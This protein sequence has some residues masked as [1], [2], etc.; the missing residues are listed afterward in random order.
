MTRDVDVAIV[1]GGPAGIAAAVAVAAQGRTPTLISDQHALGGQIWR[2]DVANPRAG[3]AKAWL[4]RLDASKC[5]TIL[6]ATAIDASSEQGARKIVLEITP[7]GVPDGVPRR[8]ELSAEAVILATG[9]RELF[10]PFPGWTLPGV[11][12][13]GG[14]QA[15]AK[16]GLDLDAKRVI[17]AGTGPL[18]IAVAAS[19]IHRGA[20]VVAIVEQAPTTR[21]LGFMA[22]LATAPRVARDALSY[23]LSL[24][25]GQVRFGSWIE[26]A[27][28]DDRI[29]RAVISNGRKKETLDCDYLAVGYGL[30]PN[31][32]IAQLMGCTISPSGIVVDERQETTVKGIFAAGE[33]VG[34]AG[35]D[36]AIAEGGIA[37]A[38]GMGAVISADLRR[39]RSDARG[40]GRR[41][42]ETFALRAEVLR[43]ATAET[44]ICRCEDVTFGTLDR[45]WTSRQAKLYTRAGMGPCQ[46]RVCGP[47]L[48]AML[49]W[50]LDRVRTPVYP[51][52]LSSLTDSINDQTPPR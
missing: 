16:G 3:A 37:A 19:L 44:I 6:G 48:R 23:G 17:I 2:R 20:N 5:E 15:M 34:I 14:L 39:D 22:R 36:A 43:L 26:S 12:G 25:P 11:T 42:A 18:L 21:M 50:Q 47:A 10:L 8:E 1:G 31:T 40:W 35:V 4:D 41:L 52:Y 33:C 38:A 46:G 28:G 9:A 13:V 51:A 29:R 45:T 30:I 27:S 49:G 7:A 24:R 32:E